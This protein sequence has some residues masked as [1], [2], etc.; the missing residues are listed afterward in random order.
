MFGLCLRVIF[1]L[2][3]G[4]KSVVGS[5]TAFA[6]IVRVIWSAFYGPE[7]AWGEVIVIVVA[8]NLSST[9]SV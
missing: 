5:F 4:P 2:T 3:L 1:C 9:N 8:A 6:V 7:A